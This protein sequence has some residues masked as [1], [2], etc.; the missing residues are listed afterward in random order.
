MKIVADAKENWREDL[1]QKSQRNYSNIP[2]K[3]N[4]AL[5]ENYEDNFQL[6]SHV[7]D[8]KLH[9]KEISLLKG[10][11]A[12]RG[13]IEM[14]L[15]ENFTDSLA[16]N[17]DIRPF[18][19]RETEKKSIICL[20]HNKSFDEE[21]IGDMQLK[22]WSNSP[23]NR[24]KRQ[25]EIERKVKFGKFR[26]KSQENVCY[27]DLFIQNI[28]KCQ[29]NEFLEKVKKIKIYKRLKIDKMFPQQ[30]MLNFQI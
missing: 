24:E 9:D 2:D 10:K 21:K 6:I 26:K 1:I 17:H 11:K 29:N 7:K 8:Y 14:K 15:P 3:R 27:S 25:K 23:R 30:K 16:Y 18:T 19:A 12:I 13:K 22:I 5:N 28:K 20:N 4:Y